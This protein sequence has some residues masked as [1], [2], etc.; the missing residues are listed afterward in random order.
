MIDIATQIDRAFAPLNVA[1]QT[2]RIPGGVLGAIDCDGNRVMRVIEAAQ[3]APDQRRMTETTWF[4][5]AS[6]TKTL[7]TTERILALAAAGTI[8]FDAPL[9]SVLPD[10]RQCNPDN[11]GRK[12]TFR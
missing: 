2:A 6:L 12:V 8:D 10:F 11:W 3:L 4:D 7:F 5:L 1:V 9:T